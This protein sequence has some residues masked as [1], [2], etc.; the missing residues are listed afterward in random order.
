MKVEWE[1]E[2]IVPGRRYGKEGLREKWVIGY[3]SFADGQ[4]RYVSIS[5]Q[6]GMVTEPK[7]KEQMARNLTE[8]G[9]LPLELI[10]EG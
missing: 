9:Y 1:A 7:A 8:N 5:D 2:D 6:D 4:E 10:R 3:L